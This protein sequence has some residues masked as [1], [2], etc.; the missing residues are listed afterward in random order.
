MNS[1]NQIALNRRR[2]LLGLAAASSTAA[3]GGTVE[4]VAAPTENPALVQL[5]DSLPTL[6]G[7]FVAAT[8][9]RNSILE[10]W[11]PRWPSSP[12]RLHVH[13]WGE[14]ETDL[15]GQRITF[16]NEYGELRY[17]SIWTSA[18]LGERIACAEQSYRRARTDVT[19]EEWR[20]NRDSFAALL[21]V[22]RKYETRC[23]R[24]Q[25][26]SGYR[27]ATRRLDAARSALLA[28]ITDTLHEEATSMVGVVIQSQAIEVAR[29]HL[30]HVDLF[31]AES[32]GKFSCGALLASSLLRFAGAAS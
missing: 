26:Q 28:N 9:A 22:A 2:L 5:G 6:V 27:P 4:A 23:L 3:T 7:E 21:P 20:D 10:E 17:R 11:V 1:F 18:T 8:E 29:A 24:V 16:R 13:G 19:R 14:D 12:K 31:L 32:K 15:T 25:E 30:H